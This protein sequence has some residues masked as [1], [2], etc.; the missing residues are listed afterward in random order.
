MIRVKI[1]GITRTSDAAWAALCGADALGFVFADSSRRVK[2]EKAASIIRRLPPFIS[3]VGVFVNAPLSEVRRILRICPLDVLQFHGEE[4]DE[5]CGRFR[6]CCKIVKVIRVSDN[7]PPAVFRSY[8]NADAFLLDTFVAGK[9]GGT[10]RTFNPSLLAGIK[11]AKPLIIAGGLNPENIRQM[12]NRFRPFGVDVSGGVEARPG[13]K[14][15]GLVRRFIRYVKM[16][17]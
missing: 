9:H 13:K 3:S 15:P 10:G 5:Y 7:I 2:P 16:I 11:T 1:C 6:K 17:E 8:R 12:L 4:D 14:D